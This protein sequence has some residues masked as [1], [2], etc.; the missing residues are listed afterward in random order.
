MTPGTPQGAGLELHAEGVGVDLHGV[1]VLDG[2]DLV[3]AAGDPV[4][5]TGPSGSG[6]TVLCLALGGVLTPDRGA[7]RL[8]GAGSPPPATPARV[9]LILQTH[10][11]VAGLTAAEN[12]SVPLRAAAVDA[13]AVDRRTASALDALGLGAEAERSVDELSGGER[14]RVGIA[15]ALALE[16]DVLVAD[17][18]TAELDAENRVRVMALLAGPGMGRRVVVVASDDPEVLAGF[19]RVLVLDGGRL[20]VG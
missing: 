10:G 14:Q 9:G 5:V 13:T 15:R 18:P 3:V 4:A 16:P 8:R 7:I 2:V 6:K 17:E 11:L 19:R 20:R 12:V 1:T